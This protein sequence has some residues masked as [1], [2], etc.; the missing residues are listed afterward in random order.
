M[1]NFGA[2]L[3]LIL[4]TNSSRIL[5]IGMCKSLGAEVR[6]GWHDQFFCSPIYETKI[7][8]FRFILFIV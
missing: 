6:D 5:H 2:V 7:R 3:P 4:V 8:E 1:L